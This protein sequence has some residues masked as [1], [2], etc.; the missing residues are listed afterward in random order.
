MNYSEI[1]KVAENI[2]ESGKLTLNNSK[3]KTMQERGKKH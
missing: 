3:Q 2:V 1:L